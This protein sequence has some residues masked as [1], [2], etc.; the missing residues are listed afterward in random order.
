MVP[1]AVRREDAEQKFSAHAGIGG[2]GG[3]PFQVGGVLDG[4]QVFV[5]RGGVGV[6]LSNR[7][8]YAPDGFDAVFFEGT[9]KVTRSLKMQQ[10]Q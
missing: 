1:A 7:V 2:V 10:R 8:F 5:K 4:Q 6:L 9:K 3:R